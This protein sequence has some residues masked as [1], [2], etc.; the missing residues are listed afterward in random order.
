[1]ELHGYCDASWGCQDDGKTVT[2]YLVKVDS[3]IVSWSSKKH[4]ATALSTA[5]AE[6]MGLSYAVQESI[7]LRNMLWDLRIVQRSLMNIYE[8]NQS[9]IAIAENST[10]KSKTKHIK[11]R[12]HF[13]REMIDA[14]E[15]QLV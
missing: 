2:G 9:C 15:V 4:T 13:T 1:L 12:Y 11:I 3:G 5:E 10:I 7:W 14:G 8:D 6:Y